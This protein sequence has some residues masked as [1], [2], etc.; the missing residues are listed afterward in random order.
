MHERATINAIIPISMPSKKGEKRR[1]K[2]KISPFFLKNQENAQ[3]KNAQKRK[4][5]R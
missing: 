3:H 4:K 1:K 2:R 5:T